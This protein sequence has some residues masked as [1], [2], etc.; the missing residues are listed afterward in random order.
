MK[1]IIKKYIEYLRY[2]VTEEDWCHVW[3][4]F[5]TVALVIMVGIALYLWFG[6]QEQKPFSSAPS[7]YPFTSPPRE[8]DYRNFYI[9]ES[10]H[11]SDEVR[12][13]VTVESF[14]NRYR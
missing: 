9:P 6:G 7:D 14:K 1:K 13:K 8:P 12:F 3:I 4:G 2:E 10:G 11:V 5:L